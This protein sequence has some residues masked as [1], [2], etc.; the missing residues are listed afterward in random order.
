MEFPIAT[1]SEGAQGA[2]GQQAEQIKQ[3]LAGQDV[4]ISRTRQEQQAQAIQMETPA[5]QEK[6]AADQAGSKPAGNPAAAPRKEEDAPVF[7]E[8]KSTVQSS[9]ANPPSAP[10]PSVAQPLEHSVYFSYDDATVLDKYDAMLLDNAAYLRSHPGLDVEVQGNCDE[11]GSREYNL[12]LGA[13]RAETVKRALELA[14]ADGSRIHAISFG[15][16]KPVAT[17]H[18]EGSWSKNRRADIVY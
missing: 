2:S 11:R 3:K 14:G 17:G 12:A 9:A 5:A 15:K 8:N 7:P 6:A 18:D 4:E 10:P 16:E 13:R 1:K